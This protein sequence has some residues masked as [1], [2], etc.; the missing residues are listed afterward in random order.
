[1]GSLELVETVLGTLKEGTEAQGFLEGAVGPCLEVC[2]DGPV[3]ML[4]GPGRGENCGRLEVGGS[5][6]FEGLKEA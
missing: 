6:E 1:M 5:S 3:D 2:K 4:K